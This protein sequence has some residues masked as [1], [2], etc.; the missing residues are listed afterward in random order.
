[1]QGS[2]GR[3]EAGLFD[4]VIIIV[5]DS[6]GIGELPDAHL[7]GDDGANTL[8]HIYRDIEDFSLPTLE[9]LGIGNIQGTKY[10]RKSSAP[11]GCYGRAAER[12]KGKDT[13]TGHWEITGI[14]LDKPF[15]TYP[16]GFPEELIRRF[17]ELV[18]RKILGNKAASGTEI[19][20]ELGAVHMETGYPIVYTSADSVFQIAAHEEIVPVE[21]LYEMCEAAREMLTGEQRVARVIA[22]PFVGKPGEFTRT[23]KRR[24]YSVEPPTATLLDHAVEQGCSV[25]AVGKIYDIFAGRGISRYVHTGSNRDGM[26][27]TMDYIK[28]NDKGIIF[29]NLVDFDMKYG[30]RNNAEGY[31]AALRDF[32]SGL[33]VLLDC[34]KKRDLLILTADHGCDPTTE[35]TD[36]SR[37]YVPIL[38]YGKMLRRGVDIGTRES[39]ADIGAT[40]ARALGIKGISAGNSFLDSI[41]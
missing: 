39:F 12:S 15:P 35:S 37:E 34:L 22:R 3:E 14:I 25:T 36:H 9:K 40:A 33:C 19:I 20:E 4:R 27:K 7:Y 29:T 38:A 30:H 11:I 21:V 2:Y 18:G 31:G 6:V 17:E 13:I 41:V 24:D 23:A 5:M 16:N 8:G 26:E 28:E 1:M 32:D 10:I